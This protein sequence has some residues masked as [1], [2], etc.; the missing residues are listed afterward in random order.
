MRTLFLL[1]LPALL[2]AG[3]N[4]LEHQGIKVTANG[5]TYSVKRI[6]PKECKSVPINNEMLWTGNY[7]NPKVPEACKSTY[8]HTKGKLLPM[9]L[10][11]ELET[12]GELEVLATIKEMQ[13][14]KNLLLI[15]SRK[16]SWF[17]YRTIPGAV[18]VPF[19]YF[20]E[21]ESYEFHFE[22]ALKSLGVTITKDEEYD[23][24]H[25]KTLVL[26][27]NGPWCSQSPSM[28]FALL[29]IGYPAEKIKWYRGG[30]QDWLGAGMTSTRD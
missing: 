30:M 25:A 6:I 24:S 4:S 1:L 15:D 29:E 18:N 23:F 5:K 27:C 3:S 8:V 13:T 20:K 11:E 12:Y 9:H 28:I 22:S 26:F 14:D 21:R 16:E 19:H 17:E 10:D 7:A 2:S